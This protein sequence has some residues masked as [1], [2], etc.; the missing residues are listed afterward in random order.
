M[1]V[2]GIEQCDSDIYIYI[3]VYIIHIL[4]VV[5]Y[6]RVLSVACCMQLDFIVYPSHIQ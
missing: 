6:E 5:V 4:Y 1:L 2:S 3:Y